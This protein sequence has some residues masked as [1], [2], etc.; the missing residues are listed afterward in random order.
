MKKLVILGGGESGVGAAIL[1]K[2]QGFHVFVSDSGAIKDHYKKELEDNEIEY[3]EKNHNREHIFKTDLVIKSPGIPDKVALVKELREVNIPIISE[4]EFASRYTDAFII[5]ITGSNGKTTTTTMTYE[6]LKEADFNVGVGG[7]IGDSFAKQVA[8]GEKRDYYVLEVS[9]FQLDDIVDFKPDIAVITNITPDHLDRY[10]Y[11]FGKYADAKFRISMNQDEKKHL[12]V[13][14][15]D[16]TSREWLTANGVNAKVHSFTAKTPENEQGA[17]TKNGWMYFNETAIMPTEELSLRGE[18]NLLNAMSAGFA[19][20][21]AGVKVAVIRK[22][23][24][25]VAAIEHR[26]EF[27]ANIKGIEFINDSKATNVDSV[28]Y[29]LDAMTKPIVWVVGGQ[30]KGNDYSSLIDLVKEKVKAIVCLGAD[31]RK[32]REVFGGMI[33][34]FEETDTAAIAVNTA[35]NL[36]TDGDVVLLSPACTSFDLFDNYAQRGRFFKE[37]VTELAKTLSTVEDFDNS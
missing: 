7:N 5:A 23:L 8:V 35:F 12:I 28:W 1:G 27:V 30:D 18:H 13:G 2:Q 20:Y 33:P 9:S 17:Y 32:I 37:A 31:N 15:D 10:D 34:V 21:L 19:A 4:I 25:Q 26:M 29:A 22:T 6:I 16:K 3:E 24:S 14:A 36:A 11:D